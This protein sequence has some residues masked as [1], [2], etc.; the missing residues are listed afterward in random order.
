[1]TERLDY[2]GRVLTE[3]DENEVVEICADFKKEGVEAVAICTLFSYL[4]DAHEKRI[5][6]IVEREM[7]GVFVSRSS[8]VLP[9]VREYER[10]S[11][12]VANAYVGPKLT[13]Y[14][15]NLEQKLKSD[16][17]EKAFYGRR[18]QR[19][20]D[21]GGDRYPACV[22]Y[23]ALRSCGRRDRRDLLCKPH[24]KPQPDPHGH[25]RHKL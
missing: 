8:E 4:N 11:T 14:L 13:V 2:L 24:A 7:P 25:G 5:K 10:S 17:L 3:L 23:A 9:Q 16:G 22:G 12:T 6:E 20:H 1:M 19:R 21:D 18:V 15:T